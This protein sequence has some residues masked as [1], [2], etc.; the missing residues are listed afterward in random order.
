MGWSTQDD[1]NN[2]PQEMSQQLC[3]GQ[4]INPFQFDQIFF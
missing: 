2:L 4:D 1:K 3:R